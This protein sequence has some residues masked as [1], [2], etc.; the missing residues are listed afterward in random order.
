MRLSLNP[1]PPLWFVVHPDREQFCDCDEDEAGLPALTSS[2]I[3][4]RYARDMEKATGRPHG[5]AR[6]APPTRRPR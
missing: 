4:R 5:V 3:A 6:Y 2:A 1:W